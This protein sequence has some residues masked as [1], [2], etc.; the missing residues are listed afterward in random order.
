M[1]VRE[2]TTILVVESDIAN[3]L[4]AE[5]ALAGLA[6]RVVH[7]RRVQDIMPD[8][9]AEI[10]LAIVTYFDVPEIEHT[11]RSLS[12]VGIENVIITTSEARP[13]V[14]QAMRQ[15]SSAEIVVKPYRLETL[16]EA[17]LRALTQNRPA[18]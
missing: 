14:I 9:A 5:H 6:Y 1:T 3:G 17:S 11:V 2:I 7:A 16:Y 8:Q 18:P 15:S 12:A 4:V 10:H 13:N